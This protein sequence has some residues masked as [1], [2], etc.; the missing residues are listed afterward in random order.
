V[1]RLVH[2]YLAAEDED[3]LSVASAGSLG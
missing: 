2:E 1:V 3:E